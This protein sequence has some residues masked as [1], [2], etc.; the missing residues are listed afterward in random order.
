MA[1]HSMSQKMEALG[2]PSSA[3][4]TDT[5]AVFLAEA[6]DPGATSLKRVGP[7]SSLRNLIWRNCCLSVGA[8][9]QPKAASHCGMIK[10]PENL[11]QQMLRGSA[12]P[13]SKQAGGCQKCTVCAETWETREPSQDE[14]LKLQIRMPFWLP[15]CA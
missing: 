15:P 6:A 3:W 4:K 10:S 13:T 8:Q 12:E 14:A 9:T 1:V 7:R 11:K 2:S 5:S